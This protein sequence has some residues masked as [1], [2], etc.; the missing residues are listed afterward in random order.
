[1]STQRLGVVAPPA[2]ASIVQTI[3]GVITIQNGSTTAT[4]TIPAVNPA[5]TQLRHLGTR[6]A[7]GNGGGDITLVLTSG[8]VITAARDFAPNT[9]GY[10]SYELT[11]WS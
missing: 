9:Y 1:M 10:V 3:R 4:A 2:G 6:A 11:E 5:K 8:S 7:D